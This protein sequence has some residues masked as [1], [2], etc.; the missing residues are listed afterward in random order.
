ME[1]ST[2]EIVGE[3]K[4]YFKHNLVKVS[5]WKNGCYTVEGKDLLHLST[6][7]C[8]AFGH[9]SLKVLFVPFS[10][11]QSQFLAKTGSFF[12]ILI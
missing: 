11:L 12:L 2:Y 1:I 7:E 3:F 8:F 5:S 4:V 9:E 6:L 10:P